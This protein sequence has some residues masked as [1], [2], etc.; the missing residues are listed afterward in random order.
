MQDS[1][2]SRQWDEKGLCYLKS[3]EKKPKGLLGAGKYSVRK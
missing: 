3:L 2:W 1:G